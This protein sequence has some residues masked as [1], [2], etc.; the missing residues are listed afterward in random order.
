MVAANVQV[1]HRTLNIELWLAV[2][3]IAFISVLS[4]SWVWAKQQCLPQFVLFLPQR[5][6]IDH[7]RILSTEI[8]APRCPLN[9]QG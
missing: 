5:W 3:G 1:E 9:P 6:H 2:V 4:L 7:R 8:P